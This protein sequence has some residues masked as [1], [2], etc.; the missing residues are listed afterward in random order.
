MSERNFHMRLR[1]G[2]EGDANKPTALEVEHQVAGEW[3]PLN[4]NTASPGFELFV[5]A[6]FTCQHTYFRVN[7]AER[8]LLLDSAEG[9]IVVGATADWSIDTLQV[10]FSGRLRSGTPARADIDYIVSRMQ[11]CPVSQNMR[12]VPGAVAS[13]TLG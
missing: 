12:A 11:Q 13:V 1:C 9:S 6:L 4:L 3:R 2:Y 8:G 5:Y 10:T 7:C